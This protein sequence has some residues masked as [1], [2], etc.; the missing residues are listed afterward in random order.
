MAFTLTSTVR[1]LMRH[2]L[3]AAVIIVAVS[4]LV[5]VGCT[6]SRSGDE[7]E[8]GRLLDHV[9]AAGAPGVFVVVRG[10][11]KV[12]SEARGFADRS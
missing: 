3:V 7:P 1:A 2:V 6:V 8:L 4:T 9:V 12:R 5:L 10:D 11:G